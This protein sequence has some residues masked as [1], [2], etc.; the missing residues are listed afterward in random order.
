M[1]KYN[2]ISQPPP[3]LPTPN[4]VELE[5]GLKL[6]L[7]LTRRGYGPG[8]ILLTPNTD[9]PLAI[10]EGVPSLLVKWAE[11]GYAVVGIEERALEKGGS[12][13]L[14]AALK[15]LSTCEKCEPKGKVGLV[16]MPPRYLF[17][18]EADVG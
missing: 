11:E 6:L 3:P 5:E 10:R 17:P 7:P 16:G 1:S 14:K 12:A 9:D 2:D 13:S 4:L 15:A 18:T 8:I